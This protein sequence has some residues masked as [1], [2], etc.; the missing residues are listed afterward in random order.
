MN[1]HRVALLEKFES[2]SYTRKTLEN[3]GAEA[4]VEV[5]K[6]GSNPMLEDILEELLKWK[7][8][9]CA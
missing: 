6:H 5:A 8:W 7:R 2:F 4:R 9:I 3:L 1:K